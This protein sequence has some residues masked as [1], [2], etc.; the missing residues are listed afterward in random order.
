M[1][2]ELLDEIE[3]PLLRSEIEAAQ[4]DSLGHIAE[5]VVSLGEDG[6]R[7]DAKAAH[8]HESETDQEK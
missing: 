7:S 3:S 5:V 6:E 1:S 8:E 4:K 2:S